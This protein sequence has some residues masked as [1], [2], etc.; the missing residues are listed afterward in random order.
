MK[1]RLAE[2]HR[3]LRLMLDGTRNGRLLVTPRLYP[4]WKDKRRRRLRRRCRTM[5]VLP[6]HRRPRALCASS[7]P[8][9]PP[10][11]IYYTPEP[12]PGALVA[13]RYIRAKRAV[14]TDHEYPNERPGRARLRASDFARGSPCVARAN[15]VAGGRERGG[16]GK[17][18]SPR[19][20]RS[21][22]FAITA[23]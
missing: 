2:Y 3:F 22:G 13:R 21:A 1:D 15:G 7:V 8:F 11:P 5:D 23:D 20:A 12:N 14:W 18:I 6:S 4:R 10:P 17:F 9:L 16:R 19:P